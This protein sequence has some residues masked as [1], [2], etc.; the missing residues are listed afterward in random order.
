M[1]CLCAVS[2]SKSTGATETRSTEGLTDGRVDEGGAALSKAGRGRGETKE[3]GKGSS[4]RG[5][6]NWSPGGGKKGATGTGID[7]VGIVIAMF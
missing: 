6:G 5:I 3:V 1:S 4:W 7:R 2:S